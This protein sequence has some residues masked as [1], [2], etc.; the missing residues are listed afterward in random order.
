MESIPKKSGIYQIRNLVNGKIYVGSSINLHVRELSHFNSLKRNDHANEKLQRAYN[1]YGLDKLIFEVLEYVEKDKLLEREQ[2]YIDTLNAVNEGYNICPL[3]VHSVD[4]TWAPAQRKSRC[5]AGNPMYGKHHSEEHKK[6]ISESE[7]GRIP[8]NKGRKMTESERLQV[9][10]YN[11]KSKRVQC[12]ETEIIFFSVRE[13]GR[14]YQINPSHISAY[15][16]GERKT[17]GGYHWEYI[18]GGL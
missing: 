10:E 7:K 14:Q 2:Y 1:K 6:R 18:S 13:A 15:A 5:G 11:G 4:Y 12:I 17:A 3:A 9:R 8:W 16:R